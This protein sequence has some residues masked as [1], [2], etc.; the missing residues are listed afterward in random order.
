MA[1]GRSPFKNENS[2]FASEENNP[3]VAKKPQTKEERSEEEVL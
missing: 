2:P 3:A 1:K